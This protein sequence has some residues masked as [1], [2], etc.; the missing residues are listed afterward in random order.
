MSSE[1]KGFSGSKTA[2]ITGAGGGIGE[3]IA[4]RSWDPNRK[5]G[6][7]CSL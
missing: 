5:I 1:K 2:L 7:I 6:D 3:A 4:L